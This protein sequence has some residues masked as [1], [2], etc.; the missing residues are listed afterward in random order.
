V[1]RLIPPD[2]N[3]MELGCGQGLLVE[4][5]AERSS[6]VTG[7][8]FDTRKCAMARRRLS[9]R[10]N[11]SIVENDL[12]SFLGVAESSTSDAI[13]LSDTLSSLPEND[14]ERVL[15]EAI[16]CLRP[17]GLLLLKIVDTTPPWKAHLAAFLSFA[18]YRLARASVTQDSRIHRRASSYYAEVL[19]RNLMTV[20]VRLLHE[21]SRS[22]IPHVAILGW[23][24][25][26]TSAGD[27]PK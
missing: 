19:E 5:I 11:V 25:S 9:G 23:K 13:V 12:I 15:T 27:R 24:N 20:D 2:G 8:D 16:R 22:V 6:H 18:I 10:T 1:A 3:V 26:G 21:E 17:G 4:L 14:Q 7:V